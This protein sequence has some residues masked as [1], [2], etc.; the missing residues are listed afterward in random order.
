MS[1]RIRL[2]GLLLSLLLAILTLSFLYPLYFM[3]INSLK[4]RAAYFASPFSLPTGRL[5]LGNFAV[6]ISQFKIL[7]LFKNSFIVSAL[8]VVFLLAVGTFAS[9]VFAKYRFKGRGALYVA[10]LM[11][12][13]IPSQVT[14][15]PLYLLFSRIGLV[16]TYWSVVLS[17]L[18]LFLPSAS[19]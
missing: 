16:S 1:A 7:N 11:T 10:V 6:M 4:A 17:Y 18:A 5:D 3:L 8:T 9:Y 13:F 2:K 19:C 14:I 12:M 15:I